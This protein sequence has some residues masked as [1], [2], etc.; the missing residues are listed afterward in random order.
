M[1]TALIEADSIRIFFQPI[2][3][4]RHTKVIGLEALTRAYDEQGEFIAPSFLFSQAKKEGA[5]FE[6]DKFVRK[7]ALQAFVPH[8]QADTG[9]FLFLNF[10]SHL[11]DQK[12]DF[13]AFEFDKIAAELGIP[14][15]SIVLEIKEDEVQNSHH[16]KLFCEHYRDLGFIIALDDFG[17][18]SS[19][20]DRLAIVRPNIV[21]LDRS[22]VF[23][24]HQNFIHQEV[25]KAITNMCFNIGALVLCEGV[26]SEEEILKA[27]RF[28]VDIFQG[29]WF[30]KP[31]PTFA[32]SP[33]LFEKIQ[34]V[35]SIHSERAKMSLHKKTRLIH[36]A[37]KHAHTIIE[38]ISTS[39]PQDL[40]AYLHQA[41]DLEAIY[42]IDAT[43]GLQIGET[44]IDISGGC[45][46]QPAKEGDNH[47]LK[48]YFYI[49]KES[50]RKNFLSQKY[51]SQASGAMCRTF[52]QVFKKDGRE[53]ILCLDLKASAFLTTA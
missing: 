20:F 13:E 21:K 9:L 43:T 12:I 29:F 48:E 51:I 8:Y 18:G 36:I 34:H 23:N 24:L 53:Q 38:K 26:E 27:L 49:T 39:T 52:A 32:P 31:S 22:L 44:I 47:A 41:E 15:R 45:F 11:L 4:I 50:Q 7:K 46:F 10:E 14:P 42:R 30:A 19:T 33:L 35:G 6:L 28:D 2:V 25:L 17:A 37:T 5:S 40:R 16:L 3:S 1:V